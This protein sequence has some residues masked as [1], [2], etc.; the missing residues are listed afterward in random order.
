[1]A[2][3]SVL[4]EYLGGSGHPVDAILADASSTHDDQVA[5]SGLLLLGGLPPDVSRHHADRGHKDQAFAHV[6]GMENHLSERRGDAAFI[7]AVP[8]AFDDAV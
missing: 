1:M 2:G 8:N 5:R 3:R 7:A 4:G 6:A